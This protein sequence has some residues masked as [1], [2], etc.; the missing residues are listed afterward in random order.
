MPTCPKGH[1][2]AD[3][4]EC[5]VCG[6]PIGARPAPAAEPEPARTWDC[7]HGHPGQTGRFCEV[8]GHDSHLPPGDQQPPAPAAAVT[9]WS[10]TAT[11]D[12]AYYDETKAGTTDLR[13]DFPR[14]L[15]PRHFPLT[16]ESLV[17]G[18]ADPTRGI[19]PD[20]DLTGPP[21]DR[22]I[23]RSH[24]MLVAHDTGWSIVDLDSTNHTFVNDIH[25]PIPPNHPTPLSAGD[26]I[27]LGAWTVLTL[28][29]D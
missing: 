1:D 26:H 7:Q 8:C 15:P 28:H 27:Y 11:A 18:R 5:D 12:R 22:A 21:E 3:P 10:I 14:Y 17:I 20:I 24:A 6:R 19:H 23:G 29:P 16:G 25:T 2:S 13:I 9:T 4:A